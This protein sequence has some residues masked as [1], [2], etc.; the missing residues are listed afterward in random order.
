MRLVTSMITN[1]TLMHI[2][3][4]MRRLFKVEN[5][6]NSGKRI[7]RPSDNPIIAS[8]SM[9]FRTSVHENEQYQQNVKQGMSWMNVTESTFHNINSTL[10]KDMRTLVVQI[11][12]GTYDTPE[13]LTTIEQIKK[14]YEALSGEMNNSFSGD[15]IFSGFRTDEPPVFIADNNRSFVI[16]QNFGV[17]DI[18]RESAFQL[19]TDSKTGLLSPVQNSISVLKLSYTGL[20]GDPVVPGFEVVSISNAHAEAYTPPAAGTTGM[21]VLHFIQETGELVMH[22]DTATNFPKEGVSVTYQKTGFNKGDINPMVY[23]TGREIT[24][25]DVNDTSH[26][27]TGTQMIYNVTQSFSRL[28][29]NAVGDMT[30]FTLEYPPYTGAA[31]INGDLRAALPPGSRIIGNTVEIPTAFFNT[32]TNVSVTYPVERDRANLVSGGVH[33]MQNTNVQGVE[34]VR[35]IGGDGIAL[36]LDKIELNASFDM[37]N[38]E[39]QYEF[40][41]HTRITINSLAKNVLTDKMFAD[42]RRFFDFATSLRTTDEEE[43]RAYHTN[44][45]DE[46]KAV[47]DAVAKQMA[48]EEAL[49]R[50]ALFQQLNNMLYLIDK[51]FDNSTKEQTALGARMVRMEL[52]QN[53]LEDDEISYRRLLS[54]NEDINIVIA[55]IERN[56]AMAL[57]TG[58]LHANANILQMSLANFLR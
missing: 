50:D 26:I 11:A 34:L 42:F 17:E 31:A 44:Q 23:F 38:Q 15:Y 27:P 22:S 49:I 18:S 46:P 2:N 21:P 3:R 16:T 5:Q 37:N 56:S 47:E 7:Q 9:L 48:D 51:H 30:V 41:A 35:A 1:T 25:R 20:G 58:S 40:A 45:G 55:E 33:I 12:N 36:P 10:L 53:R 6:V 52:V 29:G 28:A 4:N 54:N 43:L 57:F 32:N 14:L 8:R 13:T 39:I 19:L 24:V